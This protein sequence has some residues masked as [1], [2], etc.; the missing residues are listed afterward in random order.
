MLRKI[1]HEFPRIDHKFLNDY[2]TIICWERF[3]HELPRIDHKFMNNYMAIICWERFHTNYHELNINLS[4]GSSVILA[5][6]YL[7]QILYKN[8]WTIKMMIPLKHLHLWGFFTSYLICYILVWC[9]TNPEGVAEW[10]SPRFIAWLPQWF[11]EG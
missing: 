6:N 10:A 1:S 4:F 5:F 8:A 7:Q 9:W 2:M 3:Q 11:H